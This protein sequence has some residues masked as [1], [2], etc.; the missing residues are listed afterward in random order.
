MIVDNFLLVIC[1]GTEILIKENDERKRERNKIK[2]IE[3]KG[4]NGNGDFCFRTHIT[5]ADILKRSII[6]VSR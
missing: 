6:T 3:K 2:E 1:R 5:C 4:G